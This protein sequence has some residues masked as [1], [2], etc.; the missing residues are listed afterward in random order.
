MVSEYSA[1]TKSDGSGGATAAATENQNGTAQRQQQQQQQQQRR[2]SVT[3]LNCSANGGGSANGGNNKMPNGGRQVCQ[4]GTMPKLTDNNHNGII[5]NNG[6]RNSHSSCGT[7]ISALSGLQDTG[8]SKL[9]SINQQQ[10]MNIG[11][12]VATMKHNGEKQ[13][14]GN[15][16]RVGRGPPNAA[17]IETSGGK[18]SEI[19]INYRNKNFFLMLLGN[20]S[21]LKQILIFFL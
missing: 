19:K 18:V 21:N 12:T 8:A 16:I 1:S 11:S 5:K 13:P 7:T 14:N 17:T 2:Q 4:N 6:N 15:T 3:T 9:Y 10:E 20:S